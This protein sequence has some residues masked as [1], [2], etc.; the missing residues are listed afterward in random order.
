MGATREYGR[1]G[2]ARRAIYYR[3]SVMQSALLFAN[4]RRVLVSLILS[5]GVFW[6]VAHSAGRWGPLT[7][8]TPMAQGHAYAI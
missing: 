1:G 8:E 7:S 2:T 6:L 3:Y 4:F 5:P